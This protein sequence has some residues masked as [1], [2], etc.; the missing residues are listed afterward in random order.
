MASQFNIACTD[1]G[2]TVYRNQEEVA[3]Y[4]RARE[5]MEAVEALRREQGEAGAVLTSTVPPAIAHMRAR[6][7]DSQSR[8]MH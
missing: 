5:A 8:Q 2:Y 4:A 7:A 1:K 3:T 6:L